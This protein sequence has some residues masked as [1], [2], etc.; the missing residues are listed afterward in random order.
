MRSTGAAGDLGGLSLPATH[1]D[2]L[3]A[4]ALRGT[5]GE[6]VVLDL[7]GQADT[8]ANARNLADAARGLV[9]LGRIGAG[10]DQAKAWLE[11]L[12][13]IRI[14]QK[15]ADLS[16]R[17]AIPPATMQTFVEQMLSARPQAVPVAVRP[18][19]PSGSPT[20]ATPASPGQPGSAAQEGR[21]ARPAPSPRDTRSPARRVPGNAAGSGSSSGAPPAY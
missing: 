19:A 5:I 15:G 2:A 1:L 9:A 7:L 21:T 12:D 4:L 13:G 8:E 17:A 14:D 16:V 10:R 6:S 20:T 3:V 18:A 11:F